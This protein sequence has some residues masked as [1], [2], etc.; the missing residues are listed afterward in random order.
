[1]SWLFHSSLIEKLRKRKEKYKAEQSGGPPSGAIMYDGFE[2]TPD[3]IYRLEHIRNQ[4]GYR[5]IHWTDKTVA[6][7]IAEAREKH[8]TAD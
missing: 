3:C 8:E 5:A 6:E 2:L 4:N 7:L 1:C